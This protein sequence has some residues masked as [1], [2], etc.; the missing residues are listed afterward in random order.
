ML[1]LWSKALTFLFI[2]TPAAAQ[3]P[4]PPVPGCQYAYG[5][6]Y[7]GVDG[8]RA[9]EAMRTYDGTK[10]TSPEQIASYSRAAGDKTILIE[11]GNFS[12]WDFTG[13]ELSNICFV[14]TD[15]S[16]SDWTGTKA[17]GLGFI[18]SNMQHAG[19][20]G[21]RMQDILIRSSIFA[22][23]DAKA[24]D[25]T[26]GKLD[27]GW[28]GDVEGLNIDAADLT[29]FKFD[30]GITVSDG[31]PIARNGISARGTNLAFADISSFGFYDADMT[32]AIL[33]QTVISPRQLTAFKDASNMGAVFVAGGDEKVMVLPETWLVLMS[34]A[35]TAQGNDAPSFDCGEARTDI[36]KEICGEY[37]SDLRQYDRQVA[38]LYKRARKQGGGVK[39]SQ[40]AWL[41][42]RN[43]CGAA[44]YP[45]DCLRRS[46]DKRVGQLI[47]LLGEQDW[48]RPGEEALFLQD[49]LPL[50]DD[51]K[52]SP[53]YTQLVPILAGAGRS[54]LWVK[55]SVDGSLEASGDA[56]G[57]NAHLCN[58]GIKG[59]R[60]DP[61]TGWYSI[62]ESKNGV[63]R[64]YPVLRYHDGQ[65]EIYKRGKFLG[66]DDSP[67]MN[68]VSCGARAS[69]PPMV[70]MAVPA[71]VMERYRK[72]AETER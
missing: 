46:Y 61:A 22:G 33:N 64:N 17:P 42:Q 32:G 38:A 21:A 13:V 49:V 58:L 55:R 43:T 71:A 70:R 59:L 41:K 1:S 65:I 56:V 47:G 8:E 48:L 53:S 67:A 40:K 12:G 36:E 9:G 50:T 20:I 26:S 72:A 19:M 31:C 34:S 51:I 5:N 14:E 54:S 29:G 2:A 66:E 18:K 3:L 16:R 25:W 45:T 7:G 69:F 37:N 4:T 23:V 35:L 52:Q 30:C 60:F 44:E 28:E 62:A 63:A 24:A 57:A 68:Y 6:I 39:A 27:G 10:I 15:L 11:G